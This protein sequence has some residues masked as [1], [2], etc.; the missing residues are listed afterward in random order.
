MNYKK[1]K[2]I[3]LAIALAIGL[4]GCGTPPPPPEIPVSAPPQQQAKII[5]KYGGVYKVG[6]PY[7]VLG[8]WYYPKEDYNYSEVGVASWYGPDFHAKKTAN[9]E[10]YNMHA[11]TAAHR[12]LPLPSIVKVTNL[13][14]GRSLLVRVNDRGPYAR[15][16]IIDISKKGAQLLGFLEKGT[17]KVKVEIMEK[18][19]RNLKAAL[20]SGCDSVDEAF[21]A[22]STTVV[23]GE[24][25][26]EVP[27]IPLTHPAVSMKHST[28]RFY[29]QAGAFTSRNSAV[30]LS[31]RLQQFGSSRIS[32]ANVDGTLFY[33]VRVGP[34]SSHEEA[35]PVQSDIRNFGIPAARI[36]ED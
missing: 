11:L 21:A 13:E 18:E 3:S 20:L 28:G 6:N 17:A 5:K 22:P 10:Q 31:E 36:I 19:S 16:R 25:G 7:K 26:E 33:R 30:D 2:L 15:D 9:G 29:V 14:N 1:L 32:E 27:V 24:I 4:S 12:T 35:V 8:R 23:R 34:F